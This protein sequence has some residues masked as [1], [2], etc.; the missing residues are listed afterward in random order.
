MNDDS[1]FKAPENLNVSSFFSR[2]L[3]PVIGLLKAMLVVVEIENKPLTKVSQ[4]I[5]KIKQEAP[6]S[7]KRIIGTYLLA[8]A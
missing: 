1:T 3:P 7:V 4:I 5:K 8:N 2:K 6:S